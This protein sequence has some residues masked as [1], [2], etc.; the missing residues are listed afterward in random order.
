MGN[1]NQMSIWG[2]GPLLALTGGLAFG[3]ICR[4]FWHLWRVPDAWLVEVQI[5]GV[6]WG[7]IGLWFWIG[8]AVQV[9]RSQR[10]RTL[11]TTG[12]YRYSRN[13][14]Y[15]AFIVFFI[16]ASAFVSGDLMI[17]LVSVVMFAAF[18][19]LIR[20]E[21]SFLKNTFGAEYEHYARRVPQLIPFLRI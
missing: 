3:L 7:I 10:S 13:P 20:K 12:V 17:L 9:V 5:V 15:A 16:P 19:V 4:V 11:A 8:S 14:M 21:E 2:V 6:V 18:K 1:V